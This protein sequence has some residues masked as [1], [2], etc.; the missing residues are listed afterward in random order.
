MTVANI[1][2]AQRNAWKKGLRVGQKSQ[3]PKACIAN[4][5]HVLALHPAW[6]DVIAYDA[7]AECVVCRSEPPARRQDGPGIS[8]LGDWTDEHSVRTAA[9][10]SAEADFDPPTTM[11][12][13]A[14]SVLAQKRIVHPVRDYLQSL[15]WDSVPRLD[16]MLAKYFGAAD[17]EYT[18]AISARWM[19]SAVAR[20]M[21]P[22]CQADCMIV[23]EGKQ[24]GG[25]STGLEALCERKEWFADTGISI[26]DKDSYQNLRRKWLYEFGEL[27]AIKGREA[28]RVKNFVSARADHYRPS[29]GRRSRDFLRQVVFCGTTNEEAYLVDRT[30]NRRFW[31]IKSSGRVLVDEIRAVRGMLWAEAVHRFEAGEAWHVDTDEL[32]ALCEAEQADRQ[33]PDDW[34]PVV[35]E[36]LKSP[37]LPSGHQ[38]RRILDVSEGVTTDSVLLG[39]I[40]MRPAEMHHAHS[41]RAGRVLRDLGFEPAQLRRDGA[42]VRLY[43]RAVTPDTASKTGCDARAVTPNQHQDGSK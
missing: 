43:K 19:I 31:P 28:T 7:F 22:G 18:R 41:T 35:A 30:G 3:L 1:N 17:T 9:W 15:S 12:E 27:D 32:A 16:L 11:I 37:T 13:Q 38:E 5:L 25:K 21:R 4:V 33:A 40:G 20:V 36:W 2:D 39:A 23:L 34:L 29:Y 42:R 8:M 24:G 14:V 6:K 10:L 26:G